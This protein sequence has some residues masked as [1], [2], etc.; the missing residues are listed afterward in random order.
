MSDRAKCKSCGA[1]ILWAVTRNSKRMPLNAEP[2]DG[3][4]VDNTCVIDN[5]VALFGAIDRPL[6]EPRYVCHF[7]TC[8]AA[9]KH[10]KPRS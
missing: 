4:K 1:E 10:R 6:P 2:V 5:G 9:S 3:T 7:A 8:S